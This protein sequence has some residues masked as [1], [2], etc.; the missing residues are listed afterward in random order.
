VIQ[1]DLLG[2]GEAKMV[3]RGE[4]GEPHQPHIS[5]F[6][7]G[8][9]A[10][11]MVE[12]AQAGALRMMAGPVPGARSAVTVR[13]VAAGRVLSEKPVLPGD[14]PLEMAAAAGP[15]PVSVEVHP[16]GEALRLPAGAMLMDVRIEAGR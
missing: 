4:M 6:T 9:G 12:L 15:G 7:L 10:S 1:K 8:P 11:A 14:R 5:S 3:V 16:A 2:P 13:I